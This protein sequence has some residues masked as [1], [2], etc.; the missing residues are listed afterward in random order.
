MKTILATAFLLGA[1][2][3]AAF[4]SP[5]R[6]PSSRSAAMPGYDDQ[7]AGPRSSTSMPALIRLASTAPW[8]RACSRLASFGDVATAADYTEIPGLP[9]S[10]PSLPGS[11][12]ALGLNRTGYD[13]S[14]ENTKIGQMDGL[15][16]GYVDDSTPPVRRRR[17]WRSGPSNSRP[18]FRAI[19]SPPTPGETGSGSPI[20]ARLVV[21]SEADDL[22]AD[23]NN[24]TFGPMMTMPRTFGP[25]KGTGTVQAVPEPADY[26]VMIVGLGVLGLVAGGGLSPPFHELGRGRH[27]RWP[28]LAEPGCD[29][30][31]IRLIPG[32]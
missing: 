12:T 14:T 6:R 8:K 27:F 10:S 3:S 4:A 2:S 19:L 28:L 20:R 25:D 7:H 26:L 9:S 24:G 29:A 30:G 17:S 23:V 5:S 32:S 13:T 31:D 11:S 15:L 16:R 1:M 22:L 18:A 21:I